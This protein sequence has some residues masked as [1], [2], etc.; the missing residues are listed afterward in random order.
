MFTPI[1]TIGAILGIMIYS[2]IC[3]TPI[4]VFRNLPV[5]KVFARLAINIV[6]VIPVLLLILIPQDSPIWVLIIFRD[7][8]LAFL[9]ALIVSTVNRYLLVRWNLMEPFVP[10][11]ILKAETQ[12]ISR[13]EANS[14]HPGQVASNT[15]SHE[16]VPNERPNNE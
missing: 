4:D 3:P 6:I 8:L 10:D 1:G 2:Y 7:F 14:G 16:Q 13:K 12:K 5:W 11:E 15:P 9:L